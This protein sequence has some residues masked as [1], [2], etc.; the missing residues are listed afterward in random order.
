MSRALGGNL[1]VGVVAGGMTPAGIAAAILD[2]TEARDADRAQLWADKINMLADPV[3]LAADSDGYWNT[4]DEFFDD[5]SDTCLIGAE[6]NGR[7]NKAW[8]RFAAPESSLD[9]G[10]IR[11]RLTATRLTD[12]PQPSFSSD[13]TIR[14]EAVAASSPAAPT[15]YTEADA[16]S[17]TT[18]YVDWV[19]PADGY[20][21]AETFTSPTLE[22]LID[23]ISTAG[24]T[25]GGAVVLVLA[26]YMGSGGDFVNWLQG[27]FLLSWIPY[28][29]S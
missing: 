17:L 3:T 23:A 27:G 5:S 1:A 29:G 25:P 22:P 19:I 12:S 13:I 26:V 4:T 15:S 9:T 11:V 28:G 24:W 10:A 18:A 20:S 21:T 14:V 6:G 7:E 8:V 16:L 2:E